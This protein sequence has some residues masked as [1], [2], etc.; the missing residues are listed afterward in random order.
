MICL[1][2][3][4][5]GVTIRARVLRAAIKDIRERSGM[6]G[7]ELSKQLGASHG[8][9]SHWE[10]GRRLP[11]PEDMASLL[12]LVRVTGE[13]KNRLIEL[14]RHA[15]EPSWLIAGMPNIPHQ[16]AGAVESERSASTI[17]EWSRDL[18]P[19]LLQTADYARALAVAD[20]MPE[21]EIETRVLLRVGRKEV[22]T[23]R[24]PV[25]LL[26]LIG[27]DALHEKIG[28]PE[29]MVDQLRHLITMSEQDNITVQV[30]PPRIGW[31]SGLAGPFVLYDFPDAPA[32]VHLEHYSSGVFIPNEDNVQV[33]RTAVDEIRGVARSPAVTRKLLAEIAD[34]RE[35]TT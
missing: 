35:R 13:E 10:T 34:E 14:A 1:M 17:A 9:V 27:E 24:N 18:I 28:S 32:V 21:Q 33:Y 20:G 31:H 11:T 19:G 12:E 26:A 2:A 3:V 7:R 5:N 25:E 4:D 6:S 16:L 23:R 30:V 29:V 8:T 15:A 22:L